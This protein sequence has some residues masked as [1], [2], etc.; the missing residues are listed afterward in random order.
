M[1][2]NIT[3]AQLRKILFNEESN[4]Y[5]D[6]KGSSKQPNLQKIWNLIDQKQEDL[7]NTLFGLNKDID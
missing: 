1:K 2:I 6:R 5:Y 7:Q 4:P 3:E